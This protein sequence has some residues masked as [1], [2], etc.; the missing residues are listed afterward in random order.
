MYGCIFSNNSVWLCTLCV[1]FFVHC[2]C[3]FNKLIISLTYH[4]SFFHVRLCC[5]LKRHSLFFIS[6]AETETVHRKMGS[7]VVDSGTVFDPMKLHAVTRAEIDTSA[8]FESVKEAVSRF[9]GVGY[10]KPSQFK[11]S[12]FKPSQPEVCV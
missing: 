2:R 8:P 3:G 10:W 12:Q 5:L 4:S 6:M 7:D 1:W 11:P 9:G